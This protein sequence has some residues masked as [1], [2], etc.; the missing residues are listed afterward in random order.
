MEGTRTEPG[1]LESLLKDVVGLTTRK[2]VLRIAWTR[3]QPRRPKALLFVEIDEHQDV[4]CRRSRN[5]GMPIPPTFFLPIRHI[6]GRWTR[7]AS[8]RDFLNVRDSSVND[9]IPSHACRDSK[10]K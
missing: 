7:L 10:F 5:V 9:V 1:Y 3:K 6:D 4:L 2:M 8:L